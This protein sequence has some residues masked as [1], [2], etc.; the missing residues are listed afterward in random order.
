M[1]FSVVIPAYN[2]GKT[3]GKCLDSVFKQD[4]SD[5]EVLVVND[6]ST[7][8][9]KQ[10]VEQYKVRQIILK[11]NLGPAGARNAA[12]KEVRGKIIIFL[13]SDIVLRDNNA[14]SELDKIFRE[15]SGIDG[16]IMVKD[17]IPLNEGFTPLFLAYYKYYLWNQPGEFQTSFTTERSAIKKDIF[18]KV[19]YFNQQYKGADV[20]D[21]EFGYRLNEQGYK[22]HIARDIKVLHHFETFGRLI[23]KTL[24]RSW[25]WIRLFLKRKKFDSVY[26]TK[27]RGIKTLIGAVIPPLFVLSFFIPLI[28]YFLILALILYIF[29]NFGFYRFLAGEK[30]GRLILP[31]IFW[32][33]FFCFLTGVGA[34][35][36]IMVYI[37][38]RKN[39]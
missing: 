35:T 32:D 7:D 11:K 31:F 9:T 14:L 22:I 23:K 17:K 25:Q 12:I 38:R 34:G 13:D 29:Y 2:A 30:K 24:K 28:F 20:E 5:F 10:I 3:I 1:I 6:C 15:K 39:D 18:D 8:E 26:S 36:S 27:E 19:G 21:F 16:I 37:F 4:F 33:L